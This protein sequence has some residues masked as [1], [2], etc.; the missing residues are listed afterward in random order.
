VFYT[1]RGGEG[2]GGRSVVRSVEIL[3]SPFR[4]AESCHGN[5]VRQWG[6]EPLDLR[7]RRQTSV[8]SGS[9]KTHIPVLETKI[10]ILIIKNTIKSEGGVINNKRGRIL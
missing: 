4:G 7:G 5:I 3:V 10:I 6:D 2:G 9:G 1:R 8:R